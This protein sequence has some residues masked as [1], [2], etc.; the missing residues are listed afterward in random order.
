MSG[1]RSRALDASEALFRPEDFIATL[2]ADGWEPGVVPEAVVFTYGGFEGFC[3]GQPDAYTMNPMLG[4]APGRFFTV[5]ASDHRVGICCMGIG[6]PAVVSV[7]EHLVVLGVTRFVSLGT[8]GGLQAQ[9][10]PGDVVLASEAVRDEGT[11]YHYLPGDVPAL[12]DGALLARLGDAL[13]AADVAHATGSTWTIDAPYRETQ[14]EVARYRAEGVLAVEM[15]AAALFA[16]AQIRDVAL[17]SL[18]VVDGA[19]GDPIARPQFDRGAAYGRLF[20]LLPIVVE[21]LQ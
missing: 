13:T 9:H 8:A 10:R 15:E 11:S 16:V 12:P 19:F 2:R 5:A 17:A 18:L 21:T 4:P 14:A 20:A 1:P 6:A 3:G 7:L